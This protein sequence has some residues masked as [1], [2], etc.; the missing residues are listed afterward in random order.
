MSLLDR[1]R[2]TVILYPEEVVTDADGNV[3]TRPSATGI[4]R[5]KEQDNEGFETDQIYRVRLPRS[6]QG[7]VGA[8]AKL[9]WR[10][11]EWSVFGDPVRYSGSARTAH[12]DFSIR[13]Y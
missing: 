3:K 13:R 2:E 6:F 4:T 7:T 11:Q 5:R 9:V 12:Y 1:G 8:Q 10:G